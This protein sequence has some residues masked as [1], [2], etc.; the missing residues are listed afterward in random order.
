MKDL[1]KYIAVVRNS[2]SQ[3]R[4]YEGSLDVGELAV[5]LSLGLDK[6]SV[7]TTARD[8]LLWRQACGTGLTEFN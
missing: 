5:L 6:R 1:S 3:R 2:Q 7:S 4:A 8:T